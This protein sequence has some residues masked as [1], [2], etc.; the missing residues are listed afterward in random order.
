[1]GGADRGRSWRGAWG[2]L[3]SALM[4]LLRSQCTR[5][6]D[7]KVGVQLTTESAGGVREDGSMGI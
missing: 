4:R 7:S 3:V 1:M 2:T 6:S 5:V